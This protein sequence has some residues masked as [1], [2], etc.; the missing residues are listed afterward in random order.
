MAKKKYSTLTDKQPLAA[1][2]SLREKKK[3]PL[4]AVQAG[5]LPSTGQLLSSKKK[6]T[7]SDKAAKLIAM[8]I[9]N[10]MKN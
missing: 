1:P 10:M 2:K 6:V 7:I 8:A 5:D 3:N 4:K 9:S